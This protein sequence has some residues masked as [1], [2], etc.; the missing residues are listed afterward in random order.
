WE[1]GALGF[2][3]WR[4]ADSWIAC[5]SGCLGVAGAKMTCS[6]LRTSGNVRPVSVFFPQ[7]P[8][9]Q[10]QEPQRQH[11]Q[12]HMVVKAAPA[13]DLIIVQPYLLFAA[14]ETVLDGPAVMPRLRHLPQRAIR[15]RVAQVV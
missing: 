8:R 10:D 15:P 12:G 6:S 14:Q 5:R 9:L 13:A 3:R 4:H 1:G 2:R 11:H 7:A